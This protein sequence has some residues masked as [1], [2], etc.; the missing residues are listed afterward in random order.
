[1]SWQ[2]AKLAA[3]KVALPMTLKGKYIQVP[4]FDTEA[5]CRAFY[6][7]RSLGFHR[8]ILSAVRKLAWKRGTHLIVPVILT[9]TPRFR[10][11]DQAARTEVAERSF[12]ALDLGFTAPKV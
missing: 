1:M 5:D 11:L 6:P 2:D 12:M 10:R 4:D 3:E 9:A 8:M 7:E